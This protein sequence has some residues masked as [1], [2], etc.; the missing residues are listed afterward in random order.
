VGLADLTYEIPV[1]NLS[2]FDVHLPC[3]TTSH[4][5]TQFPHPSPFIS[6]CPPMSEP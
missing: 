2:S 4:H 3:Y 6:E 5:I 1:F